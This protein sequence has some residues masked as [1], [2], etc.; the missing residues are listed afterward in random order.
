MIYLWLLLRLAFPGRRERLGP[1]PESTLPQWLI[2]TCFESY[3]WY[4]VLATFWFQAWYLLALL[5]LA[6]LDPRSLAARLRG[7]FFSLGA[8]LSYVIFVF[9]LL[10]YWR[11]EPAF[12]VGL[13]ACLTI[14][15][16][17]LFTRALESWQYR[18]ASVAPP[19]NAPGFRK[20]PTRTTRHA[21]AK[22]GGC[23][24]E[25]TRTL[26]ESMLIS[27]LTIRCI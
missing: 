27:A 21:D 16:L 26:G 1:D 23:S 12:T 19:W 14:Y 6:A 15:S 22:A 25:R 7:A 11:Q 3:F 8:E 9:I 4:F 20:R 24:D 13:V 17:P 2:A 5:P 10:I 18:Q